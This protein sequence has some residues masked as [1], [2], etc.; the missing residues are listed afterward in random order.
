MNWLINASVWIQAPV[1][2]AFLLA[3]AGGV[4]WLL[5]KVLWGIIPRSAEEAEVL[6]PESVKLLAAQVEKPATPGR[7]QRSS[8]SQPERGAGADAGRCGEQESV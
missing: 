8:G 5:N 4:S 1:V 3:F 2:V 7:A 6:G